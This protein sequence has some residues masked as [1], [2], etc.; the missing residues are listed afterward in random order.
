MTEIYPKNI[1][2]ND[3]KYNLP[4]TKIAKYPLT[5]RDISA[6][7]HWNGKNIL[8]NKF[9]NLPKLLNKN[10]F[11]IF[12]NTKVIQARLIFEKETGS[13]IEIFC[14]E[15]YTP[16]DYQTAFQTTEKCEWK[17]LIGNAKRW[18]N[19]CLTKKIT[20]E[21]N[22]SNFSAKYVKPS[23]NMTHIVEFQW[24]NKKLTF[25]KILQ[26][27]GELPVPPYL[28]RKTELSDSETYQT[29]YSKVNGS[30]A[31]PTAGLHFTPEVLKNLAE[32]GIKTAE[33]TLHVG[34]GTFQPVKSDNIGL[35]T[36]H[37]EFFTVQL[38]VI[39]QIFEHLDNIVAV[40]T[41]SV[42]TLESLY[43]IGCHIKQNPNN[44]QFDVLQWEPYNND[45][46]IST[47][48]ALS[49]VINYMKNNNLSILKASTK[50]II[51]PSFK[52]RIIKKMLTNFHQPQSTLLLLVE[53][54]VGGE[55]RR[56][57]YDYALQNDF[58]FLSYGDTSLLEM[59][60][61]KQ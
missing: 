48:E 34:A 49:E 6:L 46:D 61:K 60:D 10:D 8:E 12:N 58:R 44:P 55:N 28:N 21:N 23:D 59:T 54:F 38:P 33:I 30:V 7:L 19:S 17:V 11:L 45:F 53:A 24:D 57:I 13:K 20:I 2:I 37:A 22:I 41:T 16:A 15:P 39:K 29:V 51:V 42:R 9:Y 43:Y 32:K 26:F 25:G 5:K 40:G 27:L 56:K 35:H 1:N 18:K 3:F 4:D 50:I 47:K 31:A 36:M 52:F 14:L